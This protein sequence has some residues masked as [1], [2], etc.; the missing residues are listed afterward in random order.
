MHALLGLLKKIPVDLGQGAVAERTE[1]KRIALRLVPRGEGRTALDVGCREGTQTRWLQARGYAVTSIDV[2]DAGCPGMRVVDCNRPLPFPDDSFDLVW[3][4]E[5]LEHLVDPEFSL[6][7]L[8]RVTRP[9][10]DLVLTT[11]NSYALLFRLIARLGFT[12]EKIQRKDH[13][14]FFSERDV[15]E[16]A[17]DATLYGYFPYLFIKRTI[18]SRLG[19]LTPTFVMHIRKPGG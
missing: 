11:P 8:R 13:L 17:P 7:E 3:C 2:E 9:G 5:V 19:D 18:K 1:G 14:H 4:S 16:I 12:P 15:R 6:N 10:G